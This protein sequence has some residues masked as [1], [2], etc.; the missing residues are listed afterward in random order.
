[1]A[2]P[3]IEN[4][5]IIKICKAKEFTYSDKRILWRYIVKLSYKDEN[6]YDNLLRSAKDIYGTLMSSDDIITFL[7]R[8]VNFDIINPTLKEWMLLELYL[9]EI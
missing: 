9:G 6:K 5:D 8:V 3:I 1:M 4:W 2:E 7:Q